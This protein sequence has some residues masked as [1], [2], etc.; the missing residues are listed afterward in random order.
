M[1]TWWRCRLAGSLNH[2]PHSYLHL[3]GFSPVLV[4]QNLVLSFDTIEIWFNALARNVNFKSRFLYR[5]L[6]AYLGRILPDHTWGKALWHILQM[7]GLR[8]KTLL[9]L[10][11]EMKQVRHSLHFQVGCFDMS[12]DQLF[13]GNIVAYCVLLATLQFPQAQVRCGAIFLPNFLGVIFPYT[14]HRR[15]WTQIRWSALIV[16]NTVDFR[17]CCWRR[18]REGRIV[19]GLMLNGESDLTTIST[20]DI[21]TAK[22]NYQLTPWRGVNWKEANLVELITEESLGKAQ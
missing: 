20:T 14:S 4:V 21:D 2:N 15:R 8:K 6:V 1:S 16:R 3:W 18:A 17:A 7:N 22:N 5:T 9:N 19:I 11:S 13:F 10:T 12:F